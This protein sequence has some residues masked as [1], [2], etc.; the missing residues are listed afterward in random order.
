[1]V[2]RQVQRGESENKE[3][4]D[5]NNYVFKK[6]GVQQQPNRNKT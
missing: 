3:N 5:Y 4:L 1:M 2:R 6:N